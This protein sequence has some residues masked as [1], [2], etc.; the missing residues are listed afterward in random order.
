MDLHQFDK[1][2]LCKQRWNIYFFS[3]PVS[4]IWKLFSVLFWQHSYL[5]KFNKNLLYCNRTIRNIVIRI[6]ALT[7]ITFEINMNRLSY[8][9]TALRTYLNFSLVSWPWKFK[10]I[11]SSS[12]AVFKGIYM[13]NHYSYCI[14]VNI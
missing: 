8:D 9:Q 14:Y 3:L 13:A 1:I 5:H 2:Y 7:V 4:N 11:K 12:K 6:N 10:F